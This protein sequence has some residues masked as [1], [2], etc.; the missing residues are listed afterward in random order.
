MS[1]KEI[2]LKIESDKQLLNGVEKALRTAQ[3]NIVNL[4]P[5][6]GDDP[7]DLFGF[8]RDETGLGLKRGEAYGLF[9]A[10]SELT[11]NISAGLGVPPELYDENDAASK[12]VDEALAQ[13]RQ[14]NPN[15][16]A[17]FGI[18][19]DSETGRG[20]LFAAHPVV[21]QFSPETFNLQL[22][23]T[24]RR[25]D[26][27]GYIGGIENIESGVIH[28]RMAEAGLTHSEVKTEDRNTLLG[29]KERKIWIE[30]SRNNL[31]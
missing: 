24:K 20:A 25:N 30:F 13:A 4:E 18:E 12:I 28:K 31:K 29:M 5:G 2:V 8:T 26:P 6:N 3:S 7:A 23:K 27:R 16:T 21:P 9:S 10:L 15:L 19:F 1:R 14:S 17:S 22:A 11:L